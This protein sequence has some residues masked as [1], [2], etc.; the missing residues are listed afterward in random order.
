MG[1]FLKIKQ[2]IIPTNLW[3]KCKGCEEAIYNKDLEKSDY[4]C[5]KCDYHFRVSADYRLKLMADEGTFKETDSDIECLDPLE[6]IM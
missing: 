2:S 5:P 6:F 1:W 3:M 4:V